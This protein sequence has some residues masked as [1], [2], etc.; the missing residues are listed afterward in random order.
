LSPSSNRQLERACQVT[1][2]YTGRIVPRLG[3]STIAANAREHREEADVKAVRTV[4]FTT[5]LDEAE[6]LAQTLIDSLEHEPPP[7][8]LT[9]ASILRDLSAEGVVVMISEFA[10]LDSMGANTLVLDA[11]RARLEADEPTE[12]EVATYQVLFTYST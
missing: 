4:R 7:A 12:S 8:G 3:P 1:S 11:G 6:P 9:R 2:A 5:S 10:D